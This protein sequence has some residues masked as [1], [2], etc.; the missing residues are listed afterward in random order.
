MKKMLFI[1]NIIN[2]ITNFSYPSIEAGQALG[3]EFHMAANFSG[4]QDDTAKYNVTIHHLDLARNPF[5]IKNM[6]AYKQLL[7]LI[8]EEKFDV[9]H[10]NT[11]VGGVLGRFCGKKAKVPKVIYSAHGFH[12]YKGAPFVNRVLFRRAE[13][14]MARCTDT[15]ITLNKEDYEAAK[16]FKLRNNGKVYHIPGVG[17]DTNIYQNNEVNKARLKESL[18][19]KEE[20]IVLIAMGDLIRRKNYVSSIKAI[21]KADNKG[22]HFLICGTGPELDSLKKLAKKLEIEDQIYFLGFRNDIK[23]LL[24]VADIFLFTTYQEGLPRS[25]MEAMSAGLPCIA[26]RVRGNVDLIAEGSGGFLYEPEDIN[27]FANAINTLASDKKLRKSMSKHNL[28]AIKK[29]GI[30][31]VK[32]EMKKIYERE[33]L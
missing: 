23:E 3:Y 13:M 15:I 22:L 9:I 14:W 16:R 27:G 31:N 21:K 7:N 19:L 26:S 2:R 32:I 1:S 17:V 8:Q 20:G 28:E 5:Q 10:C 29:F 24:S 33:L 25:M 4:F 6:R 11:P 30:H 18:G 12:F